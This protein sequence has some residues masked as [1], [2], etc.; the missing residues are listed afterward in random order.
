[1]GLIKKALRTLE[2]LNFHLRKPK[3]GGEV[4]P[5]KEHDLC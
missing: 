3:W 5:V 1:M 4:E 2:K